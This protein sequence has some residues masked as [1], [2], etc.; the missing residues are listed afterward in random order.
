MVIHTRLTFSL[1]SFKHI[2]DY[3]QIRVV[4][5]D[6]GTPT[7]DTV[8]TKLSPGNYEVEGENKATQV[9][10]NYIIRHILI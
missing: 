2:N 1:S 3:V 9:Q 8:F 6:Y 4:G 10:V 5:G 7:D